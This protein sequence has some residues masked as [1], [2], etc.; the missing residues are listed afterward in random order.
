MSRKKLSKTKKAAPIKLAWLEQIIKHDWPTKPAKGSMI[1]T[2]AILATYANPDGQDCYPAI[3]TVAVQARIK[4]QTVIDCIKA[5]RVAGMLEMQGKVHT[6]QNRYRLCLAA[7]PDETL[8]DIEQ[9]ASS[10]ASSIASRDTQ[11]PTLERKREGGGD[12]SPAGN[13]PAAVATGSNIGDTTTTRIAV[14]IHGEHADLIVSEFVAAFDAKFA[15]RARRS[16]VAAQRLEPHQPKL[17]TAIITKIDAGW[18]Q[19]HLIDRIIPTLPADDRII[20]LTSLVASKLTQLPDEPDHDARRF[21]TA[22]EVTAA[23]EH[24]LKEAELKLQEQTQADHL[25]R[26]HAT[27]LRHRKKAITKLRA[28]VVKYSIA[29]DKDAE[30]AKIVAEIDAEAE[31]EDDSAGWPLSEGWLEVIHDEIDSL[32]YECEHKK[33]VIDL[34]NKARHILGR[35][36]I[37][38]DNQDRCIDERLSAHNLD[39]GKINIWQYPEAISVL[40]TFIAESEHAIASISSGQQ[41]W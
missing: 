8:P 19:D 18:P 39:R 20:Y 21:I 3:S 17:R 36:G 22:Q 30:L 29:P 2:A 10:I 16:T 14:M 31:H 6:G 26:D 4:P 11:L 40:T 38:H 13:T 23:A 41:Q 34:I 37:S 1:A 33:I 24:S 7:M 28:A 12:S 35:N 9:I 5:M 27:A 15:Q 25:K 32:K